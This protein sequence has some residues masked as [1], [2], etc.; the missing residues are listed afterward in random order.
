MDRR[1]YKLLNELMKQ[2]RNRTVDD[3][4]SNKNSHTPASHGKVIVN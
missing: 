1:K 3:S 2:D 4:N